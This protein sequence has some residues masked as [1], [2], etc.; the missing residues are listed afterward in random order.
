MG[1]RGGEGY[2][3][4]EERRGGDEKGKGEEGGG[5]GGGGF[6]GKEVKGFQDGVT[7]VSVSRMT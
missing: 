2:V 6:E 5:D 3:V 1:G 7:L 4:G